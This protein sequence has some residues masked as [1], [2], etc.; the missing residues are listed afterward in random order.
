VPPR[1]AGCRKVFGVPE[2]IKPFALF[3]IGVPAEKLSA[4]YRYDQ[5][6]VHTNRW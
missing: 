3:P 4:E 1:V 5:S 6:R 2:Q